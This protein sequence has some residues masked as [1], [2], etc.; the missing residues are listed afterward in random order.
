[1]TGGLSEGRADELAAS[2]IAEL[3]KRNP[4]L[5]PSRVT[6]VILGCANQAGEDNRN[7]A[8]MAGLLA[9]LP[10]SVPG[11]TV[12]RL[13]GSGM[14]AVVDGARAIMTGEADLVVAGGVEQMTRAPLVM[15][16]PTEEFQ[17]GNQAVY[18]TPLGWRIVDQ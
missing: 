11:V 15:G 10:V 13:C 5:D 6:D 12:N 14:N 3:L 18:A 1:M 7:V 4:K 9:G 2:V 16:K 8:R 17:R